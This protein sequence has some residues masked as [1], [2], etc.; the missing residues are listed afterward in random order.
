MTEADAPWICALRVWS[1]ANCIYGLQSV[2]LL[3]SGQ[4]VVG[5]LQ[6]CE[7]G[8]RV[9]MSIDVL[10]AA[11]SLAQLRKNT[12]WWLD[13]LELQTDRVETF[14]AGAR[15]GG[16]RPSPELSAPPGGMIVGFHGRFGG[17]VGPQF[18]DLGVITVERRPSR[19]RPEPVAPRASALRDGF[20]ITGSWSF[21][22][23]QGG[24]GSFDSGGSW[25]PYAGPG[26]AAGS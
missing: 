20:D 4:Q 9:E 14:Y 23:G 1:S 5:D 15:G 6:G 21:D 7:Q 10:G 11:D 22:F 26:R 25:A 16:L 18:R 8:S 2:W 12:G 19:S 24:W 3:S 13:S 17:G